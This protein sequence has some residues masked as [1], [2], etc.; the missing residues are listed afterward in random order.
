MFKCLN[1]FLTRKW[2]EELADGGM[3]CGHRWPLVPVGQAFPHLYS[4]NPRSWCLVL[5]LMLSKGKTGETGASF[6][7]LF[8]KQKKG[9][10]LAQV[11]GGAGEGMT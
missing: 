8:M 1:C 10:L 6:F 2:L 11:P 4:C 3:C 7:Y 9:L 5:Q